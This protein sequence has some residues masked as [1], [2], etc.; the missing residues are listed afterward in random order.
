[1]AREDVD[2]KGVPTASSNERQLKKRRWCSFCIELDRQRDIE[3]KLLCKK[4]HFVCDEE[5]ELLLLFI[6]TLRQLR[7]QW[8]SSQQVTSHKAA[9]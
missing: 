4:L 2:W 6:G 8:K 5:D 7:Q 3:K 1:M 9:Q